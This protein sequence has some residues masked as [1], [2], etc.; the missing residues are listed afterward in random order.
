MNPHEV[1]DEMLAEGRAGLPAW[2]LRRGIARTAAEVGMDVPSL[3]AMFREPMPSMEYVPAPPAKDYPP[4]SP[5]WLVVLALALRIC[6]DSYV[7]RTV[8]LDLAGIPGGEVRPEARPLFALEL[9]RRF[10]EGVIGSA[11]VWAYAPETCDKVPRVII[12]DGRYST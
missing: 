5:S 1:T 3:L 8:A 10:P 4:L 7:V 9:A 6:D 11:T 2:A 12:V